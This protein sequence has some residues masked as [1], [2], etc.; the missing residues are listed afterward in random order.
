MRIASLPA[1]ATEIVCALGLEDELVAVGHDSD[2]PPSV[3]DLPALTTPLTPAPGSPGAALACRVQ[4]AALR[5]ADPD[6]VLLGEGCPAG[7]PAAARQHLA[8][9]LPGAAIVALEPVTMEGLFNAVTTVGAM[10]EAEDEAVGL[11]ELLR[12]RLLALEDRA[13]AR[14][15]EGRPARR[16]AVVRWL[17]PLHAAGE[18]VPELV[19]LA[20]G[21][22]LLGREGET[23]AP[24]DWA[25]LRDLDPDVVIVAPAGMHL[26][27]AL[28]AWRATPRPAWWGELTAVRQGEVFAVDAAYLDRVGPRLVDGVAVLAE[29]LDPAA[30]A[31][32][33]PPDAW[34][35]LAPAP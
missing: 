10:A 6:L 8:E 27:A 14:R 1:G 4:E 21:W 15:E 29:L 35:R 5:A 17:E 19:R 30:F 25:A 7:R 32:A 22:E 16:T 26:P 31:G 11:V 24:A 20:G 3:R 18:W 28:R 23:A 13:R 9:L 33:A 2:W 34:A 12:E